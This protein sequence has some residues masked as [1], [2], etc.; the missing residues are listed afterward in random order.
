MAKPKSD[1]VASVA[2]QLEHRSSEIRLTG[3][4]ALEGQKVGPLAGDEHK[5]G[6]QKSHGRFGFH[7]VKFIKHYA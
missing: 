3:N 4:A 5:D 7:T 2:S 6:Y 1:T